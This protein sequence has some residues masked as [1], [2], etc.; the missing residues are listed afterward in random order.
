MRATKLG[1][2]HEIGSGITDVKKT[3]VQPLPETVS[4]IDTPPSPPVRSKFSVR[5]QANLVCGSKFSVR[6]LPETVSGIEEN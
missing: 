3:G 6:P 1:A 5:K 4:G 2:D